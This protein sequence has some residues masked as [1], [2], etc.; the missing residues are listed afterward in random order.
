MCGEAAAC[1]EGEVQIIGRRTDSEISTIVATLNSASLQGKIVGQRRQIIDGDIEYKVRW[2]DGDDDE[3]VEENDE[4]DDEEDE[5]FAREDLKLD[6]PEAIK[7]YEMNVMLQHHDPHF[8]G[9]IE[10]EKVEEQKFFYLV[11]WIG[12]GDR[13]WF[14]RE[15]LHAE[16][17]G[18]RHA[19]QQ[20]LLVRPV[21][22]GRGRAGEGL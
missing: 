4:D 18:G 8:A 15:D 9:T 17:E 10:D 19:E 14:A 3:E 13:T 11:K 21:R 7:R 22:L 20:P 2:G 6:H 5:W 16:H 12:S 1:G